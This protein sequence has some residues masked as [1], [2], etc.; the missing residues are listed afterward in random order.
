M[1]IP[2]S[3]SSLIT[4]GKRNGRF[5]TI[6]KILLIIVVAG[7]LFWFRQPLLDLLYIVGDQE[8]VA[9]YLHKFGLFAP[10]LLATI[11]VLQVIVAAI[12]GHALIVGG[13]Y[14]FGFG[15]AFAL[16]LAATVLGSQFSFWLTRWFG[17]PLI[18]RLAPVDALNKW[19]DVSAKKGML[20]FLFAFM[21]PIFPADVMNYVAGLSSLSPRRFFVANLIGRTPGV[22]VMTAIGA[23]GFH[24][25]GMVW[26]GILMADIAMFIV[27]YT[28]LAQ[29]QTKDDEEL[30]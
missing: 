3:F 2:I 16:S 1:F 24:L 20:F 11:L 23:Y 5:L 21:L 10:L 13:G 15:P 12:P 25:S 19:Y 9:A 26:L 8:A 14:I 7:L 28:V 18:E 22:I 6:L 27:W 17:R 29:K 4:V 30:S